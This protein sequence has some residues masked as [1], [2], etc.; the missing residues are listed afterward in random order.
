M[1][2]RT[3][4]S[5]PDFISVWEDDLVKSLVAESLCIFLLFNSTAQRSWNTKKE[6]LQIEFTIFYFLVSKNM[7]VYYRF[8]LFFFFSFFF[9]NNYIIMIC[10]YIYIC[11]WMLNERILVD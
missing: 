3:N 5:F 7:L 10:F 4:D 2:I 6:F 1:Y 9:S 11:T 8:A